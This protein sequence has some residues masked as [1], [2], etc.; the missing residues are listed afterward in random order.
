MCLLLT[1][2][3]WTDM[4]ERSNLTAGSRPFVTAEHM[5]SF[6][7]RAAIAHMSLCDTC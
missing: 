1:V 5:I 2:S 6:D 7:D 3:K 4:A